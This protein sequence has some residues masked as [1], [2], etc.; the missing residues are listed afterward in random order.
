MIKLN[1]LFKTTKQ[2]VKIQG[3]QS[4]PISKIIMGNPNRKMNL[5][6]K[7]SKNSKKVFRKTIQAQL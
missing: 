6:M 4:P 1:K 2:I 3:A 7:M 5:L